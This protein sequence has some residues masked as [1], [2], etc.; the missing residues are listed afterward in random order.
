VPAVAKR[1]GL[2]VAA[3]VVALVSAAICWLPFVGAITALV[4][5]ILGISAWVSAR[6]GRRGG[7]GMAI[8]ATFVG[9]GALLMSVLLTVLLTSFFSAIVDCANPAYTE[10]QTNQCINDQLGR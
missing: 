6:A 2:A 1:T 3:L 10:E 5:L 9:L 8:A 4:G 7:Q